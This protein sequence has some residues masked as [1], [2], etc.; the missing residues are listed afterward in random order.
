M[1]EETIIVSEGV[2]EIKEGA[3]EDCRNLKKIILLTICIFT[4]T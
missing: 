1:D 4:I 2:T 3:F